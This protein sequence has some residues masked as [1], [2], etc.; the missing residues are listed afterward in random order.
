M[1]Q[2][3]WLLSLLP[4]WVY[5]LL[6]LISVLAVIAT[7]VLGTIPFISTNILPIRVGSMLIFIFC[8][9]MEGGIVN[10]AKWK[11]RVDELEKKV[12]VAEKAAAEATGKIETVYIDRVQVVKEKQLVIQDTIRKNA[13]DLDLVCKIPATVI[14]LLNESAKSPD[15]GGKK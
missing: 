6:L 12:A 3:M 11:A 5:H 1:W 10:E 7:H 13:K 9:W 15:T 2:I 8:V 4:D 14:N